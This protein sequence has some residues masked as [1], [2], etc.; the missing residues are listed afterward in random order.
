MS[1][2][3]SGEELTAIG[4]YILC[5]KCKEKLIYDKPIYTY[6]YHTN[7]EWWQDRFGEELKMICPN[8]REKKTNE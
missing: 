6:K 8:C 1:K 7:R 2:L 4:D 3:I 5:S